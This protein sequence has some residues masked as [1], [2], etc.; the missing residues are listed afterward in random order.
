MKVGI[1]GAGADKFTVQTEEIARASIRQFL[2]SQPVELVI[3]GEAPVGGIDIWAREEALKMNL[4][5]QPYP[6]EVHKWDGE[7][8]IGFKQRNLQI[9]NNSDVVLCL[10]VVDY[11][12][13]YKFSP[14]EMKQGYHEC[15]TCYHCNDR[16]PPHVKSGGCW[17]AWKCK[18][19]LWG[20]I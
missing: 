6:P 17:T 16:L 8:K 5:F 18:Q 1:V 10:V 7:G 4:P 20:L 11:P 3:S 15:P 13:G 9:A 14:W 19:H 12:E 2:E